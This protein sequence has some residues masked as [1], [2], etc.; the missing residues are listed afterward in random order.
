MTSQV[1][2][3]FQLT[4]RDFDWLR[5]TANQ[6]SGIMLPDAK[7]EMVYGRLTKRLR[8]L[9][10][11]RFSD[12]R[13][14]VE[15]PGNTEFREFI[16][17][18]TTNLTSFFREPHHFD[19]L[20]N[21]ALPER[22]EARLQQGKPRQ[23]RIW[24]AGCSTGQEPYSILM[25]IRDRLPKA[26]SWEVRLL[27]TDL[28][29]QVLARAEEGVY[30]DDSIQGLDPNVLRRWFLRGAGS[31][32]GKVRVRP[33]LPLL[34]HFE[35]FNLV[36][37]WTNPW[38]EPFDVIF[39]RNVVI[40]FDKATQRDLFARFADSLAPG[41]YLYQGHSESLFQI[42]DRFIAAGRTTYQLPAALA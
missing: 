26:D 28:D 34:V 20:V 18:L 41:G 4:D 38:G 2:N 39:C 25:A 10:L 7:R 37:P 40:Y 12:Y 9:G 17:S 27:A 14:L 19:H 35:Q 42:S 32:T 24:S 1:E 5:R 21:V 29:T 36:Q 13:K 11:R 16:N 31:L 3:E 15:Q 6:Y 23:L 33:D 22:M 8:V 30:P